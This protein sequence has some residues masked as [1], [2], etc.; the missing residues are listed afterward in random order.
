[1]AHLPSEP[2]A[3]LLAQVFP[4]V[5][6]EQ[7]A[8][9]S[10]TRDNP[11]SN[12]MA[13]KQFLRLLIWLRKVLLQDAAVLFTQDPTF[14]IFRYSIFQSTTFRAF[15][16]ASQL[17]LTDAEEKARLAFEHLPD[18]LI[19]SLRGV[20]AD[21]RME[22]QQDR[23][24]HRRQLSAMDERFSRVE[25][26]LEAL[27]GAKGHGWRGKTGETHF[28][29][30]FSR[31]FTQSMANLHSPA[32]RVTSTLPGIYSFSPNANTATAATATSPNNPFCP[33]NS[34]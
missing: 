13:L 16:A 10:R 11:L 22:Q 17:T 2:P 5:E 29:L 15:A 14:P 8:L 30:W 31:S 23:E 21:T 1:V 32:T 25:T 28:Q 9:L 24:E 33:H 18:H 19:R 26:L 4:W 3:E 20:L 7:A 6:R 34:P 12:D 27:A